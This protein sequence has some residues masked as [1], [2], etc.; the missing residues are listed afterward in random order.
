[1][2]VPA[3]LNRTSYAGNGVTVAFAFPYF[4]IQKADM[5]VYGYNNTTRAITLYALTADY[6]INTVAAANGTFPSGVTVTMNIAPAAGI[7][8]IL[9]RVPDF[10]QSTHWVDADPDPSAVKELAFDKA[11][12][13]SIRL[14]DL[15]NRSVKLLDGDATTFDPTLPTNIAA[16][17]L[18]SLI[19]NA[20]GTGWDLALPASAGLSP[21]TP[22]GNGFA[23][24]V[25]VQLAM[26]ALNPRIH[27]S[28]AAPVSIA[29][30]GFTGGNAADVGVIEQIWYVKG[31]GG[32]P[33]DLSAVNPPISA[34][35][36]VGQSI[37]IHGCDDVATVTLANNAGFV[38]NGSR[39]FKNGTVGAWR[40]DGALWCEKFF[41][42]L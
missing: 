27:G 34:G 16:S 6:L 15:L 2:T 42:N 37:E 40:W 1:V 8:L 12:L 3:I 23:N 13:E 33:I 14:L 20:L 31:S 39:L 24:D 5:R 11:D 17:P 25:T 9:V 21:Y 38:A 26:D 41:N 18:A 4:L 22:P 35:T 28:R 32:V 30:I 36:R 19:V 10:L 7:T 29:G